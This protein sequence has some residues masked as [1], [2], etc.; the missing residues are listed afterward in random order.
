MT[1][2]KNIDWPSILD[3]IAREDKGCATRVRHAIACCDGDEADLMSLQDWKEFPNIG[4]KTVR[5]LVKNAPHLR[6]HRHHP[7][8]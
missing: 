3:R 6:S 5:L 8:P 7:S 2:K 1:L 4:K